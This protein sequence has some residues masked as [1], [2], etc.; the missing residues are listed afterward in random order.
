MPIGS[1]P[2]VDTHVHFWDIARSDLY[3]MTPDLVEQVRPLQRTFTPDDL[4]PLRREVGVDRIVIVQAARSAW[5]HQWWFSLTERYDWIVA[6]V[7]WVDLAAPTV[8][9]RLGEL[10][11]HPAFRGVRATAENESDVAWLARPDVQRGIAAVAE[12]GLTLDLLVRTEHLSFVP[13]LAERFP[14]LPLVVDHL[15]KPPIATGALDTWRQRISALQPYPNVWFKLSGLLTE[16]GPQPRCDAIRPVVD[17]ALERFGPQ[18]LLWGSDWPVA[19]LAA[20]YRTT[21]ECYRTLTASLSEEQR[22]AIFGGNA[23]RVYRLP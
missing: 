16:A 11:Q 14:T 4:D 1:V 6:V 20:D 12:R 15:A 3:W 9:Q 17:F 5:D 2:I 23:R 18:R 13:A 19:T 22:A 10:A 21:F 7:G 8:E